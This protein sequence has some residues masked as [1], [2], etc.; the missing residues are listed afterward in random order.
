MVKKFKAINELQL[1]Y[2]LNSIT[3]G[4]SIATEFLRPLAEL[5]VPKLP[6]L[7]CLIIGALTS[8]SSH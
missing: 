8:L 6:W 2:I 3:F 4:Q 5:H 1:L 7:K